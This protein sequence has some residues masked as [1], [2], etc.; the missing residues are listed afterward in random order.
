LKRKHLFTSALCK[1]RNSQRKELRK[2]HKIREK[3]TE[4]QID[5]ISSPPSPA[6]MRERESKENEKEKKR[7]DVSG[8]G[9]V[10]VVKRGV[11]GGKGTFNERV[12]CVW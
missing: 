10:E 6:R 7:I 3:E 11:M 8:S 4:R 2:K 12:R 5:V 1:R 9:G